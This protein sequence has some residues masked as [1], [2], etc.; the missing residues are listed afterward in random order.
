MIIVHGNSMSRLD[1]LR[2]LSIT[3]ASAYLSLVITYRNDPGQPVASGRL[4]GLSSGE[5]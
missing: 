3:E 4:T 5:L 1:G 2:M